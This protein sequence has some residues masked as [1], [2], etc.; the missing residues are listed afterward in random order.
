MTHFVLPAVLWRHLWNQDPVG[1]TGQSAHQSQVAEKEAR[2]KGLGTKRSGQSPE[3]EGQSLPAVPAHHLQHEGSLVTEEPAKT[4]RSEQRIKC[5]QGGSD[6]PLG[7]RH[8]GIDH[9]DDPVQGR[10]RPDGHV[11]PA[12]VIVDGADHAH[13]VEGRI[14]LNGILLDQAWKDEG[15]GVNP[16]SGVSPCFYCNYGLQ[17]KC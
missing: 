17:S 8:D 12:E 3:R 11:S 7:R 15:V 2:V 9:L 16:A 4:V 10:V 5:S 14:F 6:S 1:S 13:D